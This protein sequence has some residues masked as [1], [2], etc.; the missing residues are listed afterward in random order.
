MAKIRSIAGRT[1]FATVL[2]IISTP[3]YFEKAS[4]TTSTASPV[5]NGPH[6][7]GFALSSVGTSLA[8]YAIGDPQ[9]SLYFRA[10]LGTTTLKAKAAWF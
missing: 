7:E 8:G 2:L 9:K 10:F 3:G 4:M 6:F 1:S 5:G